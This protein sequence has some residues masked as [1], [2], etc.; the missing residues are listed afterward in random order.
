MQS[1]I[2]DARAWFLV[3]ELSGESGVIPGTRNNS[4]LATP[5]LVIGGLNSE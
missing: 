5:N 4:V 2:T 3:L 1:N